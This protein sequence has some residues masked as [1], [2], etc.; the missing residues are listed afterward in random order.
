MPT[1]EKQRAANR[2]NAAKSTGPRTTEGKARSSQ[3]ARKYSFTPG[4]FAVVRVENPEL[5]ENLRADAIATYQPVTS[6]E[7]FAVER[8]AL[9]QLSML[10]LSAMEAGLFSNYLDEAMNS[11]EQPVPSDGQWAANGFRRVAQQSNVVALFLRYQAQAERL[12]RR[13]IDD[14]T[15]LRKHFPEPVPELIEETPNEPIPGPQPVETKT[16]PPTSTRKENQTPS[17]LRPSQSRSPQQT[18]PPLR[19]QVLP[20]QN[21]APQR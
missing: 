14:F 6:Q 2:A 16:P 19:S 21:S 15:R 20:F 3:N 17:G 5:V 12:Y 11:P 18:Q 1:T 7:I 4:N 10:R 9:A 13:A 8:I